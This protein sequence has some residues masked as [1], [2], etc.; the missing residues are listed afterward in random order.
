MV[1]YYCKEKK[2]SLIKKYVLVLSICFIWSS[3][4]IIIIFADHNYFGLIKHMVLL[5]KYKFLA[6]YL[7]GPFWFIFCYSF[8]N[9]NPDKVFK[10]RSRNFKRVCIF[11]FFLPEIILYLIYLTNDYLHNW[12]LYWPPEGCQFR[13]A[14]WISIASTVIYLIAGGAFLIRNTRKSCSSNNQLFA[15]M[16]SLFIPTLIA[17]VYWTLDLYSYFGYFDITPALFLLM[18]ILLNIATY[19]YNFLSI[20]PLAYHR[21]I[22][23]LNDIIIIID[24][25][26][27]IVSI[28]ESYYNHFSNAPKLNEGDGIV[29]FTNMLVNKLKS[30]AQVNMIINAIKNGTVSN[31]RGELYLFEEEKYLTVDI[32]PLYD[33][34]ENVGRVIK[35]SDV[36]GYRELLGKLEEKNGELETK[37]KHLKDYADTI[38]ELAVS[39]ERNRFARDVHDSIGHTMSVLLS[40]LGA[41]TVLSKNEQH[42]KSK[43]EEALSIAKDGLSELRRSVY[44]LCSKNLDTY[45]LINALKELAKEFEAT[46]I[47]VDLSIEGRCIEEGINYSDTIFKIC[48]EALTNSLK[49]GKATHISV[50]I[51]FTP[52]LT[53]IFIIDNGI[54]CL[55]IKKGMGLSGMEQRIA[56]INGNIVC[57]SDGEKGFS[58]HIEIP[59]TASEPPHNIKEVLS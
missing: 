45:N 11:L 37:N 43:L 33:N 40:L 38:E 42:L 48:K 54:G 50:F 17:T 46:G 3:G 34:N 27:K 31:E 23:N 10:G 57:G 49:H 41:C 22:D 55:E 39:K 21:V 25:N 6:A 51:E 28:N 12:V 30:D 36:T 32:Q 5:N 59:V 2:T 58:I 47:K 8:L 13:P 24:K 9:N 18:L 19:K 1:K 7:W 29:Q 56:K 35:L 15:V 26:H 4:D 16:S 52:V 44:G 14:F 20:L 53:K